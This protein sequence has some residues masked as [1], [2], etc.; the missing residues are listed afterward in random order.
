MA[1]NYKIKMKD[2][3]NKYKFK[4][5]CA[6]YEYDDTELRNEISQRALISE[7][8]R[9][10][11]LELNPNTYV[12]TAKLKDKNNNVISTSTP[13]DL[14]LE[15]MIVDCDYDATT[16]SLIITLQNGNTTSIPLGDLISGLATEEDLE[17]VD[18]KVD[19]NIEKISD[20]EN[21]LNQYKTIY[22]VLP[23]VEDEGEA[24]TLNDTG[25]ATLKM[26]LKGNSSQDGTSTPSSPIA[27][28]VVS[29]DN[30]INICGKNLFNGETE[31]GT[32]SNTNGEKTAST[33][34]R[35]SVNKIP[36]KPNQQYVFS[37]NGTAFAVRIYYYQENETFIS[38]EA[39]TN[40][41]ITTPNNC[42]YVNFISDRI[43][44]NYNDIQLEQGNQASNYE[45][46]IG[47][48]YN[49]DL[50]VKNLW[51]SEDIKSGFL[52]QSGSY[53]TTNPSFPNSE[54]I[55][56]PLMEGQK[57]TLSGSTRATGRVRCIDASTNQVV[58]AFT[59][60]D[61]EYYYTTHTFGDGF[62]EATITAKKYFIVGIMDYGGTNND[63]VVNYGATPQYISDT[64]IELCKIGD[65]QD[66]IKKS[67]GK[68]LWGGTFELG[69]IDTTTGQ[70]G[71]STDRV[72][73]KGY[74][75]VKPNTT[76][77]LSG[78]QGSRVVCFY[79]SSKAYLSYA[80]VGSQSTSGTFTTPSNTSYI[81][82]YI[83]QTNT[84]I[85]EMLNEGST[86]LPYEPY[87]TG[88]YV[89]KEIGK[90]VLDGSQNIPLASGTPRRFNATYSTLGITNAKDGTTATDTQAN[91]RM[92]DHFDYTSGQTTWGNYYLHNN[93]LVMLDSG[94]VIASASDLSTWL[95]NN[96]TT[97]Y[98]VLATPT[99][100]LIEDTN[101]IEQLEALESAM[102]YKGQTNISQI[103]NDAPFIIDA[104][105]LKDLSNL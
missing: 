46:Y 59:I 49:I 36:V 7:A 75:E 92:C 79:N 8:G 89:K 44:S 51:N 41:I 61:T 33:N 67:T 95:S 24:F 71:A 76:Y 98:Y 70:D 35:R 90:F 13:I 14:P 1:N 10:V 87:G 43:L 22:N 3:Q 96:N 74:V 50:G 86:A 100:T 60:G 45:P 101:F 40:G 9:Y 93:W 104:T 30:E 82:W 34:T 84:N 18:A 64:P 54:Y 66:S 80:V 31:L 21:E 29:G 83:I 27:I 20:L 57:L 19:A 72:R 56:V 91:Y 81:R 47:N 69:G 4:I 38:T 39:Y 63:L 53:P 105:A 6:G 15:S 17:E 68:N 28:N 55:L 62:Y 88:W 58:N 99:N 37:Q 97:I 32:F 42:Y 73:T 16:K 12:L 103:N 23:K 11:E 5:F 78:V 94:S 102:S 77:T 26:D 25:N 85:N 2:I 65:Y 48:T 52:P